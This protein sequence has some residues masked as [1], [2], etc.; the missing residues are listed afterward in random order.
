M[1]SLARLPQIPILIHQPDGTMVPI[2]L[3][4]VDKPEKKPPMGVYMPDRRFLVSCWSTEIDRLGIYKSPKCTEAFSLQCL[5]GD[6]IP[7]APKLIYGSVAITH[8]PNR[9]E[10][11]FQSVWYNLLSSLKVNRCITREFRTFPPPLSVDCITKPQYCALSSKILLVHKYWNKDSIIRNMLT[12]AYHV[13]QTKVEI[14]GNILAFPY[15]SRGCLATHGFLKNL[16]QLCWK[17]F[18]SQE[19]Q[20]QQFGC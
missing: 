11:T 17:L 2:S 19:G 15:D 1:K 12:A 8:D 16:R 20:Y 18:Q 14:R 7:T 3:H 9:L 4:P 10:K 13:F 5:D 6:K